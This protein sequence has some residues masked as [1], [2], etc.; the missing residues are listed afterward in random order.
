M[1]GRVILI[2]LA[3]FLA[4]CAVLEV[5]LHI[6]SPRENPLLVPHD[7]AAIA[8]PVFSHPLRADFDGYRE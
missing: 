3:V 1:R 5:A 6:V 8:D 4:L 2:N 7:K